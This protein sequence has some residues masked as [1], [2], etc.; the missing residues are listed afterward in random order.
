MKFFKSSEWKTWISILHYKITMRKLSL[1]TE[2]R[3]LLYI[4]LEIQSLKHTYVPKTR[5]IIVTALVV[6]SGATWSNHTKNQKKNYK[7]I[8]YS[9]TFYSNKIFKLIKDFRIFF[10]F[11][12]LI[13]DINLIALQS[14][15]KV[16]FYMLSNNF[17]YLQVTFTY[18]FDNSDVFFLFLLQ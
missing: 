13:H 12:W 7:K 8:F 3:G 14:N 2:S 1:I 18:V 4:C 17:F 5:F 11:Q 9:K 10:I 6:G 15:S 16:T